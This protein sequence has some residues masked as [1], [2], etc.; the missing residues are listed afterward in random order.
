MTKAGSFNPHVHGARGLFAAMVFVFHVANS[1]LPT[2]SPVASGLPYQAAMSLQFGVELFFG[3]S[4]F[5]IVGAIAR[6]PS[7]RAFLW[8][9]ATRIYPVL[10]ISLVA[11]SIAALALDRWRPPPGEWILNFVAPPPFIHIGQINPAAW[12]LGY[13]L[14]FYA[15][16]ALAWWLRPRLPGTWL[17][18]AGVLGAVLIVLFPR[19]LLIPAGILIALGRGESRPWRAL[20]AVPGCW[21]VLFLALWRWSDVAS[22]SVQTASPVVLPSAIWLGVLP[23]MLVAGVCGGLALNGIAAGRGTIGRLLSTRVF[24]W[25]GSVSYSFY[26][27]HP[28]AMATVKAVME[29]MDVPAALG[30][31]S[32]LAFGALSLPP[33]LVAAHVSQRWLEVGLTRWLRRHGPREDAGHA[34]VTA[35]AADGAGTGPA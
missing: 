15:L 33:A 4:G 22:G 14:T 26:L 30:P 27:W 8:D 9:R 7:V 19:A 18:I 1:G 35:R 17:W 3:I 24:Q 20:S 11:I 13:E 31:W 34:P 10:W 12:S 28:V 2:F 21:L 6:A 25:L 16:V 29:K 32:Q 5:V 23:A